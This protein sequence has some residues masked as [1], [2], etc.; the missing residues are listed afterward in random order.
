MR[1]ISTSFELPPRRPL[2]YSISTPRMLDNELW[3][4]RRWTDFMNVVVGWLVRRS[5]NKWLGWTVDRQTSQ[6]I[7]FNRLSRS[8]SLIRGMSYRN[9]KHSQLVVF[10]SGQRSDIRSS[11]SVAPTYFFAA[12]DVVGRPHYHTSI[13]HL[14]K[15]SEAWI[16]QSNN[17]SRHSFNLLF[18]DEPQD[19]QFPQPTAQ[20]YELI[21]VSVEQ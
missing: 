8:S 15:Y 17:I 7:N 16:C 2:F 1:V 6:A 4:R 21:P 13:H 3:S 20:R 10:E 19:K 9:L 14:T 12:V 11:L 18:T 5:G